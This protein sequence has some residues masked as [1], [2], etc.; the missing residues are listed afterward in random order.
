M[1]MSMGVSMYVSMSVT[2]TVFLRTYPYPYLHIPEHLQKG[3]TLR[4]NTSVTVL[5]LDICSEFHLRHLQ[6][7][8]ESNQTQ[9][10]LEFGIVAT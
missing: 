6:V 2:R 9:L 7:R 3:D 1:S 5:L 10:Q 8:L 4:G